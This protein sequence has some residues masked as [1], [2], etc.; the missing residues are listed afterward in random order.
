M[1]ANALEYLK[2]VREA[3]HQ[4][5]WGTDVQEVENALATLRAIDPNHG[6]IRPLEGRAARLLISDVRRKLTRVSH[7]SATRTGVVVQFPS[8]S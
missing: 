8:R 1:N 2:A 7:E 6:L 4:F 3:Y 5:D